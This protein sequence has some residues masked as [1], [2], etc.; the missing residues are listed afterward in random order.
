MSRRSP[1]VAKTIGKQDPA[2]DGLDISSGPECIALGKLVVNSMSPMQKKENWTNRAY[3]RIAEVKG[4][5]PHD[6]RLGRNRT[7]AGR[8]STMAMRAMSA[9]RNGTTPL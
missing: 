2:L 5:D 9:I 6:I 1:L 7:I 8:V 4:L 3:R